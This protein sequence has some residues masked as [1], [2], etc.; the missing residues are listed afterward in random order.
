MKP[1]T[2]LQLGK[3]GL[4]EAFVEQVRNIFENDKMV[5]ISILKS[6]CRDRD[7]ARK[8]GEDLV[9]RLGPKFGFKLIGYV[10]TIS[11]FRKNQR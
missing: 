11:K 7:D 8:I 9:D 4:S 6:A 2:Q 3:A 1:I 10:L 5:K